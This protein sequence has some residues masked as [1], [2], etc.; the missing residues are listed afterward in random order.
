[1]RDAAVRGGDGTTKWQ[2]LQT[3]L[4]KTLKALPADTTFDLYLY[5][6]PSKYPPRPKLTRAF[7]KRLTATPANVNKALRWMANPKQAPKGWGA[8]YEPLE[9]VLAEDV[10]TV[11]LLSDGRPSRGRYDRDFRILQEFPRANR[12]RRLAVN[13]VLLGTHKADRKFMQDLAAATGGR[14]RASSP[15]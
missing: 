1:M 7:G 5:R 4:E 2:L 6:Y 15:K 8:F 10:D 3:E 11:I 12:F 13:T 14:F 9:A